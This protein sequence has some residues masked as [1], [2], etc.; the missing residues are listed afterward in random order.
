MLIKKADDKA[1]RLRLL[2][3]LQDSRLLDAWQ[4]E[5]L[6][7][8]LDL[9]KKGIAGERDA[10][11]Y[12]DAHYRD[13]DNYALIHDLRVV[14][15]GEVA[16][17]DHL[18]VSRGLHFYLLET[19]NYNGN[20]AITEAGEFSVTYSGERTF[21]IPSPLEQSKRHAV[22][23]K[24]L[25]IKLEIG[26]RLGTEPAIHHVVLVDP[27]ATIQRPP[28]KVLDTSMVIKA[29]QF[30]TWHERFVEKQV[31]VGALFATILNLRGSNEL[32]ALAEKIVRQHRPADP[33]ALPEHLQPRAALSVA[34]PAPSRYVSP[35]PQPQPQPQ[36]PRNSLVVARQ[37]AA[38]STPSPPTV[39]APATRGEA[40]GPVAEPG[41]S[42]RKLVCAT[43]GG[44]ITFAEGRFCWNQPARFGGLQYCREHQAAF[45]PQ[46]SA[47]RGL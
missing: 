36:H 18:M 30:R 40:A 13:H 14:V 2:Q 26:G 47:A 4:K 19:K 31:G 11:H 28:A 41:A 24:K 46:Q 43:C 6:R 3:D 32:K 21:G 35:V 8:D 20:L 10:A 12:I 39:S 1:K 5:R 25:L 29:D 45:G 17:I 42:A 33:L 22:I 15:D 27:K 34:E 9:L 16:Q 37:P 44:R 23:L 7:K 38:P